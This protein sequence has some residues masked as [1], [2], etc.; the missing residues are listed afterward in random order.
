[1]NIDIASYDR[2]II[3]TSAG[4]DSQVML[5]EV[6]IIAAMAGVKPRVLGVH[7]DL[8]R[9]EWK[10]TKELAQEQCEHYGVPLRVVSRPQ[11]D[12]L[13]QVRQRGMWP[14]SKQRY[15]TSDHKRDQVA[16]VIREFK[17]KILNC[18]GLRA[19]ESP[20][21]AKK[22]PFQVNHRLTTRDRL[23]H[24]WLPI[25]DWTLDR[26][27][28]R[29]KLTGVRHHPAY[30]LGMPRLSCVFCIFASKKALMLA[31]KHNPELLDEYV[32]VEKDTGHSFRK[33]FRIAEVKSSLQAG[34]ACDSIPDWKM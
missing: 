11:G 6:M 18:M 33:D 12:L 20:A 15:C 9:M 16:K 3:N 27:W 25:H 21:R 1:M 24:D 19:D 26:V 8:G 34:E 31:G 28:A 14:S 5:D 10:G 22:I 4:K 29:I 13:S 23:V 2:I 30:D 32:Q 7:A 17:G